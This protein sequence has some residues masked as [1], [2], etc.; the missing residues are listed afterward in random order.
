MA[1]DAGLSRC[2]H[3]P[4]RRC[5][6]LYAKT[7]TTTRRTCSSTARSGTGPSPPGCTATILCRAVE[8]IEIS[9]KA[10]VRRGVVFHSHRHAF[11]TF[12]RGKVPDELLRAWSA[13]GRTHDGPLL[14][15]GDGCDQGAGEGPGRAPRERNMRVS[16][17]LRAEI[18][19]RSAIYYFLG[20]RASRS[21][22]ATD[23]RC[24]RPLRVQ[25]HRRRGRRAAASRTNRCR[26]SGL[27]GRCRRWRPLA[28]SRLSAPRIALPART[29]RKE[30]G[31]IKGRRPSRWGDRDRAAEVQAYFE[32]HGPRPSPRTPKRRGRQGGRERDEVSEGHIWRM[33]KDGAVSFGQNADGNP[34]KGSDEANRIRGGSNL[35][36]LR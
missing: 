30:E 26:G 11:N 29:G 34:R 33:L 9:E 4:P 25:V 6:A 8:A 2:P 36:D 23:A 17:Q 12:C 28:G 7:N 21:R 27:R 15:P 24:R 10:R 22:M 31:G 20:S 5:S 32:R 13:P 14:P 18:E 16:A 3:G 35:E 19:S 1:Q